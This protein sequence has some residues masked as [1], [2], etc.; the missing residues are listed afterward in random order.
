ML[1]QEMLMKAIARSVLSAAVLACAAQGIAEAAPPQYRVD[2][3][4]SNGGPVSRGNSIDNRGWI[5]G[6]SML[7]SGLRHAT[8]WTNEGK[9]DLGTLGGLD[10]QSTVAWPVKSN[11][12]VL[13]GISQTSTRDPYQ[14]PWSCSAFFSVGI[15]HPT[16]LGFVWKDGVMKPLSTLGG[17]NGFAAGA[18]NHGQIIGWAETASPDPSCTNG[19]VLGFR[20]VVWG[21]REGEMHELPPLAGDSAS[22]ATAINERGQ[23]VGIS[24]RCDQAIG[25]Y[26]ARHAVLWENGTV[27]DIGNLGGDSWHTPTAINQ[28]GDVAGFSN[29]PEAPAGVYQPIA[30]IWTR[31]GGMKRLLL[32]GDLYSQAQGI[33]AS[34]QV[35]GSSCDKDDHCRAFLWQDDVMYDLK[36]LV[37]GLPENQVLQQAMD[38][39]DDGVITGRAIDPTSGELPAFVAVPIDDTA[40]AKKHD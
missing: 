1:T 22:A 13:V 32:P 23:V 2:Y 24:G 3:L 20:A 7:P 35:V 37:P 5:S 16:C 28:H 17:N 15:D 11:N 8:L 40:V 36:Q 6:Y 39:N 26:T 10:R 21:P 30:F 12:G 31:D 18:N 14:E 9:L 38:I 34:R 27:K 29:P 19:Q 33:N 4:P 25:R